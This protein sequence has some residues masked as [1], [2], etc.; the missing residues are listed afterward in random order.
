[1]WDVGGQDKIR[2]MWKY[3]FQNTKG[4]IYV[5]DSADSERFEIARETLQSI[6]A[7]EDMRGMINR[8]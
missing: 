7:D 1:V 5:I 2:I 3:Y 4:L 8:N 6:V